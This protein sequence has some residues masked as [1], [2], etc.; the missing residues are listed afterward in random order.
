MALVRT[1]FGPDRTATRRAGGVTGAVDRALPFPHHTAVDHLTLQHGRITIFTGALP[2]DAAA[3]TDLNET[4]VFTLRVDHAATPGGA[5]AA[6]LRT[7]DAFLGA[8]NSLDPTVHGQGAVAAN[9]L[10]LEYDSI[11]DVLGNPA[12]TPSAAAQAQ[13]LA[14]GWTG[15]AAPVNICAPARNAAGRV[16]I[17]S[18]KTVVV[19]NLHMIRSLREAYSAY[20]AAVTAGAQHAMI[21]GVTVAVR[22][23]G[24]AGSSQPGP[25]ARSLAGSSPGHAGSCIRSSHGCLLCW[26]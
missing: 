11:L 13:L 18:H 8:H 25:R 16:T 21:D 5:W 9:Y 2:Q 26:S 19:T 22:G 6:P 7:T 3:F 12:W 23:V 24:A 20:V 15:I 17:G 14:A 10:V 4:G 1:G